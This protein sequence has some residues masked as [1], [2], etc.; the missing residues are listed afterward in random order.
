MG[1]QKV[2]KRQW[3]CRPQVQEGHNAESAVLLFCLISTDNPEEQIDK[4]KSQQED[5]ED[6]GSKEEQK[7]ECN[8]R[9]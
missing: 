8:S 2:E 5:T 1:R 7:P 6:R 3:V 4:H 9:Q